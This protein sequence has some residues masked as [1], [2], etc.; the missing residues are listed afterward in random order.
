MPQQLIIHNLRPITELKI[1]LQDILIF[2]GSQANSSVQFE[3]D[4]I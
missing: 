3:K 4:K 2:T 1:E